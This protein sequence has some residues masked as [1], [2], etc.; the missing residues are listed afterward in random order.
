[1]A[2]ETISNRLQKNS[3]L[4]IALNFTALWR[5]KY[6][7]ATKVLQTHAQFSFGLF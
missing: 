6:P 2:N 7:V 5:G 4:S 3:D 1:M